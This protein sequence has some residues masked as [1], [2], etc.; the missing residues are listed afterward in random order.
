MKVFVDTN[1]LIDYVGKR[2]PFFIP[3]KSVFAMCYLGKIE[4]VISG[5]SIVNLLYI[6]RKLDLSSLKSK[7]LGLSQYIEIV[8]LPSE[9]ILS[10]LKSGWTDYEDFLQHET[11]LANK[12]DCILTRN[13]DD[14]SISSLPVYNASDFI[15]LLCGR[16]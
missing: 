15:A 14:F 12:C 2:E 13:P 10:G 11:A 16:V 8:D 9:M 6:C 5:L 3:A 4:I 7:L 1:I